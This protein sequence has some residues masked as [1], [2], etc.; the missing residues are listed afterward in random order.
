MP[1]AE[2]FHLLSPNYLRLVA[3]LPK[4][5]E[6]AMHRGKLFRLGDPIPVQLLKGLPR[7]RG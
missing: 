5:L 1:L 7:M 3:L 6:L 4:P 2:P